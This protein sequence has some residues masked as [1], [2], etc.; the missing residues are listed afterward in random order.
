MKEK[1]IE[2]L[3]Y[4]MKKTRENGSSLPI[5]FLG[6]GAS[7]TGG[8]PLASEI[9]ADILDKY[10]DNPTVKNYVTSHE[11]YS[12]SEL[13]E[14]LIPSERN[15]LLKGYVDDAKI[16][17]THIYLAQLMTEGFIDYVLTVNF[18]NL[19]L[20]A[21][22]LFDE[23]PPTYDMAILND[24]TTT[25]L[26][27]KS[28]VYL[29]GQHHGLWL[30]NTSEEMDKVNDVIPPI[31][32][33]IKDRP[34]IFI[35]Y[36]GEDPIFKHIKNLGRF[37]KGLYWVTY[38]DSNPR[39]SVCNELFERTN[40]N[41]HL[42]KGYDS[43][44]F[45]VKLNSSL[46]LPQ[47]SVIDKPF[48]SL[49]KSLDNIV[50]IDDKEH[51]QGVK[52]R[53]EIAKEQVGIAINQFEC[54]VIR[55]VEE[56]K[57]E[58][59]KDLLKKQVI[60]L[61]VNEKFDKFEIE[62]LHKTIE[63]FNDEELMELMAQLYNNWGISISKLAKLNNDEILYE[64]SFERYAKAA[65][66]GP[67]EFSIYANWGLAISDLAMLNHDEV[68]FKQG[69]DKFEKA[70]ELEPNDS[71][72]YYN[73]GIVIF[74]LAKLKDNEALYTQSIEKFKKAAELEPNRSSIY[75]NWGVAI[76]Y[77]ATMKKDEVLFN[78][79]F[80]KYEKAARLEP[81]DSLIYS[82]WGASI[83]DLAKLKNDP[84]FYKKCVSRLIE[85]QKNGG[86]VYNLSCAYAL[87]N[88]KENAFK[89]LEKVLSNN[90]I[91]I[92]HVQKDEDWDAYRQ[93]AEFI[94]L[95]DKFNHYTNDCK[96]FASRFSVLDN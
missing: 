49:K 53:L 95:L 42:I 30:L 41:C 48:S 94:E 12:Y 56:L 39:E 61:I 72:I 81:H 24:L 27:K 16:N 23:F 80:E 8:I 88:E 51:F 92:E 54:G 57:T 78:E 26:N 59:H 37:D 71:S 93:D 33:S 32:N 5:V 76:A 14:C 84:G 69:L 46:E 90:E 45:M 65:E 58:I 17:V 64:Q 68:L 34:W 19:M 6:A 60:E 7:K 66:L 96:E 70:A 15:E 67:I 89:Y 79:C 74:E 22:A 43:D 25:T 77:L 82:N 29:H 2:E 47:P 85:L 10:K 75:S 40:T 31:L 38:N 91:S 36:S 44:S 50:D 55:S 35:G 28:V 86:A 18:D 3:A 13:M 63:I 9:I 11:K 52:E 1:T 21:L 83:L 73:L 62:N 20:R 87:N 4:L